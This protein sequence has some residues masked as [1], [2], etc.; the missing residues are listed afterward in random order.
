MAEV[1]GLV[2]AV[3]EAVGLKRGGIYVIEYAEPLSQDAYARLSEQFREI[4][5]ELGVRFLLFDCGLRLSASIDDIEA[6]VERV[7]EKML[8][9]ITGNQEFFG[10]SGPVCDI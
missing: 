1:P 4:G 7:I 2:V 3:H 10:P 8:P 6:V 9:R 5:E